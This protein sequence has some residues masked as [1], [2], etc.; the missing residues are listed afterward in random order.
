MR[1][2]KVKVYRR[3]CYAWLL[4]ISFQLGFPTSGFALTS[5]PSTP[6][7]Q[8][9]EPVGTSE[10]VDLFSGDFSY[11]IPLLDVGGYPINLAYHAGVGL[12]DEASWV[13][14]GWN[15]NP[16]AINRNL[17]G[18]PDDFSGEE[19]VR[20]VKIRDNITTSFSLKPNLELLGI[21]KPKNTNN[22]L[23][24]HVGVRYN[25][26][27]GM[28][29]FAGADYAF[30]VKKMGAFGLNANL[31][32]ST[33]NGISI[34][35]SISTS[36]ILKNKEG[37]ELS[38]QIGIGAPFNSR[39]GLKELTF[40]KKISEKTTK[41]GIKLINKFLFQVN[42]AQTSVG[43]GSAGTMLSFNTPS[44]QTHIEHNA[45]AFSFSLNVDPGVA[46]PLINI[47]G[48]IGASY[49]QHY[50]DG[51]RKVKGYGYLYHQLANINSD[52]V[53]FNR[54]KD[55]T[56]FE[57]SPHL[58]LTNVTNDIYSVS[59]QG[60]GG[61][62][63][64]F[65]NQIGFVSDPI[66]KTSS[67]SNSQGFEIGV[68]GGP[69]TFKGGQNI[70]VQA[71]NSYSKTWTTENLAVDDYTFRNNPSANVP[72][73]QKIKYEPFYFKPLGEI[74][75]DL[76][77]YDDMDQDKPLAFDLNGHIL[78]ENFLNATPEI[79]PQDKP[80]SIRNQ[81]MSVITYK[82]A[83][84]VSPDL[85]A[86]NIQ[87]GLV[88]GRLQVVSG[89]NAAVRFDGVDPSLVP[90]DDQ[91][92]GISTLDNSG[93]KYVYNLPVYNLKK[94]E[95]TFNSNGAIDL[96]NNTVAYIA[97]DVST[98]SGSEGNENGEDN[99]V[100]RE[101]MPAYVYSYLLTSV[102]SDDYIDVD[103]NGPSDSD[104]GTWVRFN[105][106]MNASVREPYKWRFPVTTGATN[107][108]GV[109]N[110]DEGLKS[111]TSDDKGSFVYG[112]KELWNVHSIESRTHIAVFYTSE[113]SDARGVTNEFGELSTTSQV[114]KLDRI[115]YFAKNDLRNQGDLAIPIKTVHFKYAIS[116]SN[117]L[118]AGV[119]NAATGRGKLTLKEVYF[120]YG[121]SN[122]GSFSKYKFD[123]NVNPNYN[124]DYLDRWGNYK[125]AN[126]NGMSNKDFPYTE[127][128]PT[129]ADAYARSWNLS[130]ITLPSGGT[131]NVDY[132]ADDYA[133]VQNKRAGQMS[134]VKGCSPNEPTQFS[135]VTNYLSNPI[136]GNLYLTV[137]EWDN[138][139]TDLPSSNQDFYNQYL[140][141]LGKL[142]FKFL[143]D[144]KD[145]RKEYVPGYCD[146]EKYGIFADPT[147]N[148]TYGWVKIRGVEHE[149]EDIGNVN[150]ISKAAWQF[151]RL[152][153]PTIVYGGPSSE[154]GA[155][156]EF[157]SSMWT[158]LTKEVP[159]M[160]TGINKS[161]MLEGYAKQFD[162]DKSF[163][164][165][166]NPTFSKKGGG[167]RVKSIRMHD[168]W[169]AIRN[170]NLPNDASYGQRYFYKTLHQM[171]DG[172]E[173][174]IS[175][176]VASY[177]PALGNDE[178]P[179][180]Q[181]VVTRQSLTLA[182]DNE[183]YM[184]TPF[185][186]SFY[187]GASVGYSKV[188]VADLRDGIETSKTSTG[189]TINE[190]HTVKDFPYKTLINRGKQK[191]DP[192]N[193]L[194]NLIGFKSKD[195]VTASQGYSVILND[196]HGKPKSTYSHG[197]AIAKVSNDLQLTIDDVKSL[198]K[199]SGVEYKYR[200]LDDNSL[201]NKVKAIDNQGEII[202][203][204]IGVESEMVLD[205]R[206]HY[207][208][209]ERYGV[210]VNFD[211]WV[212]GFFGFTFPSVW[213]NGSFDETRFRSAVA[214]KL[215]NKH[216][217][218]DKIQAYQYGSMIETSNLLYDELTG[219]VL[220]TSVSNEYREVD[221][222]QVQNANE[223]NLIY[224]FKYPAHWAYSGMQG[225]YQNI[226]AKTY[227][228]LDP[229]GLAVI[230][231]ENNSAISV[232]ESEIFEVGDKIE[233]E[234][235]VK[236]NA[237]G[238]QYTYQKEDIFWVNQV[239]QSS[240]SLIDKEGV[241]VTS[242]QYPNSS[243]IIDPEYPISVKIMQSGHKNKQTEP[244]ANLVSKKNPV[245]YF[246][247]TNYQTELNQL[248]D[249]AN[250]LEVLDFSAQ[251]YSDEWLVECRTGTYTD[252][253]E[254]IYTLNIYDDYEN[255]P[256]NGLN[257]VNIEVQ[258]DVLEYS[259]SFDNVVFK[260][261]TENNQPEV[262][263]ET[264]SDLTRKLVTNMYVPI[265]SN[266]WTQSMDDYNPFYIRN[267]KLY[268]HYID[269]GQD[270][271]TPLVVP[272]A[273]PSAQTGFD[274]NINQIYTVNDSDLYFY[275]NSDKAIF[276]LAI[277][278]CI[279]NYLA[280]LNPVYLEVDNYEIFPASGFAGDDGIN[281]RFTAQNNTVGHWVGILQNVNDSGVT[282]F[283]NDVGFSGGSIMPNPP[284]T[285]FYSQDCNLVG[286][287][288][289][290]NEF[291]SPEFY[292]L[293]PSSLATVQPL[294]C[295]FCNYS[296]ICPEETQLPC[297]PTAS[298]DMNP[299]LTGNRGQ[300]RP[301]VSYVHKQVPRSQVT[302]PTTNEN[303]LNKSGYYTNFDQFWMK[304]ATPGLWQADPQNYIK[305]NE[306][307]KYS[308]FGEALESKD[309][310][311]IYSSV[312]MGY[313]QKLPIAVAS[314]AAYNEIGFDGFE[315]YDFL[316]YTDG[317]GC[318]AKLHLDLEPSSTGTVVDEK[319]HT[320]FKSMK[321]PSNQN[322]SITFNI[323]CFE[324]TPTPSL[325]CEYCLP[326]FNP[327]FTPDNGANKY[328]V[329]LWIYQ[330]SSN[331][332]GEVFIKFPD[333][334]PYADY[335][336]LVPAGPTIDGWQ[337]V[338]GFFNLQDDNSDLKLEIS[339]ANNSS[340]IY[341][342]DVRIYPYDA[343]MKSFVYNPT[344]L[345]LM[346]EL[347]E[348]NHATFYEYDEEW[349]MIRVKKETERG[350]VTISENVSNIRQ[351][352]Q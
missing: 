336:P 191:V 208:K 20:D 121:K 272:L 286:S 290:Q 57:N 186:E 218:L 80:R 116:G 327:I 168:N 31:G 109:A 117:E 101:T 313:D 41:V 185:G 70:N 54:E 180:K 332:N 139:A 335:G 11:N 7:V 91:I 83:E 302:D 300:W 255:N 229:A 12:E 142:Y 222:D 217:L 189:Y 320:G 36:K 60:F 346:A 234:Y 97:K 136:N 294:N 53:D 64:P 310:L 350:I 201:D 334:S 266:F 228:N 240:I 291:S 206:E 190:F 61:V 10:M 205:F 65:R 118:C 251:E 343:N 4:C 37:K 287:Y 270:I 193:I 104:L 161:M 138:T 169:T 324:D 55:G 132:E 88:N 82:E 303:L 211:S 261:C 299:F 135:D 163:V 16:G 59:S 245:A 106:S 328:V 33:D 76:G 51:S 38:G 79:K 295:N 125:A 165:L 120:T 133:F 9:F 71:L 288:L 69:L 98:A 49:S 221:S 68:V 196:M 112:E 254:C 148:K 345:K 351:V 22:S 95:V 171:P 264:H 278:N 323:D 326:H 39:E 263:N 45:N 26:Y 331:N 213:G 305:A 223:D 129:L 273:P 253:V 141:G 339:N 90:K 244:I 341:I 134:I 19:I 183:F 281:I 123:Y 145:G 146:I 170:S 265:P 298:S 172:S 158:I 84:K 89:E 122:K 195:F 40:K 212:F 92:F 296:N 147:T 43:V 289:F 230:V 304:P 325:D 25:N 166:L 6:E 81:P 35:P 226:G 258:D 137:V 119:P 292:S 67:T 17:R 13:G 126:S 248:T 182:P 24:A 96:N 187:P 215:I 63:R 29:L 342:D 227:L 2:V 329:D 352:T 23:S 86:F 297:S 309:A 333:A 184:E 219:E 203:A 100:S 164:R 225:A 241:L 199:I 306:I 107:A 282:H 15:I 176:G 275:P 257:T 27:K 198:N 236:V 308:A 128:D 239:S 50:I 311:D 3:I 93:K 256:V 175:S 250:N 42:V 330:G 188:I 105:Y 338:Y 235:K 231:D 178:N 87:P 259:I 5:G 28:S 34:N 179:L 209:I 243:S 252:S 78:K 66:T 321:I 340:P 162:P 285:Y 144:L 202:D 349:N 94:E 277:L 47:M 260:N 269:N 204:T 238:F 274:A 242:E 18:L 200:M 344:S 153:L 48:E 276:T 130:Q 279:K 293:E 318:R 317:E 210:E 197:G 249:Q 32:L 151:A 280:S 114:K 177:E 268:S 348:N 312:V 127:Q 233:V 319:A 8:S 14:L 75:S 74:T 307:T 316:D 108:M 159:R 267:I 262:S 152:Y 111:T 110:F 315:E 58:A 72:I 322:F 216:G 113:R 124:K 102:L 73:A 167:C 174:F 44:Y 160:L 156:H 154:T 131:I 77:K 181:P 284:F 150:P 1:N 232:N 143:V 30:E 140:D 347:D 283:I 246:D 155:T 192:P 21:S 314:N 115:E 337:R 103:N 85:W 220:L 149:G 214:T 62:Y 247:A 173:K 99:F 56:F 237:N 271:L 157:L 52:I 194:Q 46:P 207:S 224:N 301:K